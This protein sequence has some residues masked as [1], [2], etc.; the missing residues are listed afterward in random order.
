MPDSIEV[1][2]NGDNSNYRSVMGDSADVTGK[3]F[4]KIEARLFGTRAVAAAVGTALGLHLSEIAD[5]VARFV[6]GFSA[7]EEAALK[8]LE[9]V[10]AQTTEVLKQQFASRNSQAQTLT[11]AQTEMSRLLKEQAVL[12]NQ[13]SDG[14]KTYVNNIRSTETTW[15]NITDGLSFT[16]ATTQ[17]ITDLEANKLAIQKQAGVIQSAQAAVD[18]TSLGV[19]QEKTRS[20]VADL[21]TQPKLVLL[22]AQQRDLAQQIL[23]FKGQGK[24]LDILNADARKVAAEIEATQHAENKQYREGIAALDEE[25]QKYAAD[26]YDILVAQAKVFSGRTDLENAELEVFRLVNQEL[27]IRQQIESI[28]A[29]P[30]KER[31]DAE[32]NQLVTLITQDSTI[33]G[34]IVVKK[35][36][37][38]T[39]QDQGT[40][41]KAV[42]DQLS[43]QGAEAAAFVTQL[44]AQ[45]A[46]INNIADA[47]DNASLSVTQK[48]NGKD[49][50]QLSDAE[51]QGKIATLKSE[52]FDTNADSS[53]NQW[54]KDILTSNEQGLAD[55]AQQELTKRT[56]FRG[57]VSALGQD[58]ALSLYSP[59]DRQQLQG[60]LGS[61]DTGKA[62]AD[63]LTTIS[64]QLGNSGLFP[65]G[66][67][68]VPPTG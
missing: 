39:I 6:I 60:Y 17:A 20:A 41:E 58:A 66:T 4:D 65:T 53:G 63:T 29:I 8:H 5:S 10:G 16:K 40:A 24:D 25:D 27:V 50:T 57:Q 34:Q 18:K 48:S 49:N 43:Q 1:R 15:E 22:Y 19:A 45:A 33:Q 47:W 37:V 35:E 68:V 31:T 32:K 2:L 61:G 67:V 46:A 38:K 51:L 12:Q 56:T 21:D 9:E 64:Q 44:D 11:A 7:D 23:N 42:A 30:V 59:A 52:I 26:N 54:L 28:L 55:A 36:L 62:V 13:I 14:S 3:T